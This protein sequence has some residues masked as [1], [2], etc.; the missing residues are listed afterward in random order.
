VESRVLDAALRCVS[1]WGISKTTLEDLAREAGCS[2]ASL[3]RAFPGGRDAVLQRLVERELAGLTTTVLARLEEA[4]S[5]EDCLVAGIH[6]A[7][8][9]I[10]GHAAFQAVLAYEPDIALP[11]LTFS[12]MDRILG[13]AARLSAPALAR[14]L[15]AD[16]ERAGEW[17]CRVLASYL[18]CPSS[19]V[20][21]TDEESVRNLVGR[22]L[23]PALE[24][25]SLLDSSRSSANPA[26][27]PAGPRK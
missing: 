26:T 1:R 16:A 12:S 19:E 20:D 17:V 8:T 4:P 2:R 27:A 21:L 25:R 5:L 22:F 18:I 14:W 13:G 7:A 10:A 11:H 23:L 3:Y 24:P 9:W 15:G 6:A